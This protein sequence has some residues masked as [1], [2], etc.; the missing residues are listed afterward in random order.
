MDWVI[1]L[2]PVYHD[3]QCAIAI[4]DGLRSAPAG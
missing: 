3:A 1:A 2:M 4:I